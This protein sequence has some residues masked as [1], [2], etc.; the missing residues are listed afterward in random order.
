MQDLSVDDM[1]GASNGEMQSSDNLLKISDDVRG[2]MGLKIRDKK[3]AKNA[4]S[5]R[6]GTVQAVYK[7]D[8]KV[9][10][11]EHEAQRTSMT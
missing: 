11:W 1:P 4:K 6:N 7:S 2:D 9:D 8:E 5:H 3:T 10:R